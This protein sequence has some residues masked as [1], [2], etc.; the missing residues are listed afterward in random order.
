[1]EEE[2]H[3]LLH[4]L[5]GSHDSCQSVFDNLDSSGY[6]VQYC[7]SSATSAWILEVASL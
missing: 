2:I 1:M 3:L 6:E 7:E 5:V 4:S